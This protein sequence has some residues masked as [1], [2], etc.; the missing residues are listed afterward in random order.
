M[1]RAGVESSG[2]SA[3]PTP[4]AP[5]SPSPTRPLQVPH[6]PLRTPPIFYIRENALDGSVTDLTDRREHHFVGHR[7]SIS[8]MIGFANWIASEIAQIVAGRAPGIDSLICELARSS[9]IARAMP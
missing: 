8:V 9:R 3:L 6:T 5:Q 7:L 4:E 1:E 2:P